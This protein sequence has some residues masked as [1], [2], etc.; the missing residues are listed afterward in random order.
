MAYTNGK[1]VTQDYVRVLMW[2]NLTASKGLKE[3]KE[4]RAMMTPSQIAEAQK[5][6]ADGDRKVTKEEAKSHHTAMREKYKK[7]HGENKATY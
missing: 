2:L 6:D 3:A 7:H 5:M 4:S 1:G